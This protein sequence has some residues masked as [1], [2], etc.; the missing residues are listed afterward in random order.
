MLRWTRFAFVNDLIFSVSETES[1]VQNEVR[2]L[3]SLSLFFK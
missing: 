2:T 1:T 3:S